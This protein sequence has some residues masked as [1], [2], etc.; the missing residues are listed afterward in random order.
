MEQA[1]IYAALV[2]AQ[3]EF[4][5]VLFDSVNPH[6]KSKFA[7]YASIRKATFPHLNKHGIAVS[8]PWEHVP[9]SSGDIILFTKLIHESGECIIS[10]CLIAKGT[11]TDQQIGGS[12]TYQRRYQLASILGISAEEDDDGNMDA[13]RKPIKEE[14][15]KSFELENVEFISNVTGYS[16]FMKKHDLNNPESLKSQYVFDVSKKTPH[17]VKKIIEIAMK[18]ENHFEETFEKWKNLTQKNN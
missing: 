4:E 8:Q 11:K 6:F 3:I 7:S 15:S 1:K 9:G 13:S 2:K 5:P 14:K 10:S 17:S 18:N 12:L 16:E